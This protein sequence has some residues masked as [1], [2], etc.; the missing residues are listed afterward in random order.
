MILL[1][2]AKTPHQDL[3]ETIKPK[4]AVHQC[5]LEGPSLKYKHSSIIV[6]SKFP[7]ELKSFLPNLLFLLYI[8]D[9]M[10]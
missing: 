2:Y 5:M 10:I 7:R 1:N 4:R 9:G 6:V 8:L 3:I